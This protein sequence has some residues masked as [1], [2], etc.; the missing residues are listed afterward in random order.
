VFALERPA[1]DL[2]WLR[3]LQRLAD[4]HPRLYFGFGFSLLSVPGIVCSIIFSVQSQAS[5]ISDLVS[6][7]ILCILM[8]G[9]LFSKRY[10]LDRVAVKHVA[11]SF[12]FAIYVTLLATDVALNIR[13]VCTIDKHP[14]VD[15]ADAFAMLLFCLCILLP[16]SAAVGADFYFGKCLQC[17]V[18]VVLSIFHNLCR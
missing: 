1:L 2:R 7:S 17:C 16:S 4:A 5:G 11:L 10:G 6:T 13:E 8:F 15:V 14:L 12:R 18:S 9:F 3:P